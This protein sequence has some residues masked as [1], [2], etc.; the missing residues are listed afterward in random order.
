EELP[1]GPDTPV[2]TANFS[3]VL[4]LQGAA[5]ALA[6]RAGRLDEARE[7][8]RAHDRWLEWSEAVL[9][10]AEGQFGW[11]ALHRVAGDDALARRHAE[12]ALDC[13]SEPRQPPALL[14]AQRLLGELDAVEGRHAAAA[15]RLE[16]TMAPADARPPPEEPPPAL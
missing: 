14:A 15:E 6:L 5:T 4:V 3:T 12:A 10:R 9:G 7:W 11:A 2:G 1:D 8:L 13:A 16:H